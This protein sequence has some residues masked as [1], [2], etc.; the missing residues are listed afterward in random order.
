MTK[1]KTAAKPKKKTIWQQ[2][3]KYQRQKDPEK[4]LKDVLKNYDKKEYAAFKKDPESF[5][6]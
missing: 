1:T 4:T 5:V 2:F 6:E 3:I